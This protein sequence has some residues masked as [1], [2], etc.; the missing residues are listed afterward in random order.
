ML[1]TGSCCPS[2]HTSAARFPETMSILQSQVDN[3]AACRHPPQQGRVRVEKLSSKPALCIIKSVTYH[4]FSGCSQ[5]LS[6]WLRSDSERQNLSP[7]PSPSSA[8]RWR[9]DCNWLTHH[10]QQCNATGL[11]GM[12]SSS[13]KNKMILTAPIQ[14]TIAEVWGD[15]GNLD[16][17]R[18]ALTSILCKSSWS[19]W[20][21]FICSH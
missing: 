21:I 17:A 19:L 11:A 15:Y 2:G 7:V 20:I 1:L 13:P 16:Q 10:Q 9:Q 18:K 4:S 3:S 12:H 8:E 6:C 5:T 14:T